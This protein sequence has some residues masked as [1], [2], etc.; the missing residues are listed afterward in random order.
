MSSIASVPGTGWPRGGIIGAQTVGQ[1]P[2]A[3]STVVNRMWELRSAEA[4]SE[5]QRAPQAASPVPRRPAA[6]A[7]S[8]T[9]DVACQAAQGPGTAV[10]IVPAQLTPK[11]SPISR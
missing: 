1:P 8:G 7:C 6:R 3:A 2:A 10:A 5:I 4:S 11:S 9:L